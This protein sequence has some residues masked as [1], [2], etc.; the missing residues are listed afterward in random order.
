MVLRY[1]ILILWFAVSLEAN[2]GTIE[3]SANP[4]EFN[5]KT[6]GT[7]SSRGEI[8]ALL[9]ITKFNSAKAWPAT[10]YIGFHEGK[11]RDNSVQFLIIRNHETDTYL[12]A[13]FRVIE[14][15][16]EV[17]VA[18][19]ANLSLDAKPQVS[20]SIESGLVTLK[21]SSVDPVTFRTHLNRVSPYI[22]VSS[23]TAEFNIAP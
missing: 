23:G 10:A 14:N 12:V 22:S 16:R 6:I 8:S 21:L 18:S 1:L 17:K 4:G 5:A 9:Q 7:S 19:L 15:G 20:I 13:G 2:A 11:N 3:L